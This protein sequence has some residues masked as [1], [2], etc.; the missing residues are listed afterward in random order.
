MR[1]MMTKKLKLDSCKASYVFCIFCCLF[2]HREKNEKDC[3]WS[4]CTLFWMKL[5]GFYK[6]E[7]I[8]KTKF[9]L[10]EA[11]LEP[12]Q[13]SN[14]EPFSISVNSF[15]VSTIFCKTLHLRSLIGIWIH[16][17]HCYVSYYCCNFQSKC[18]L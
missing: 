2:T 8:W 9:H 3:A 11:Y 12:C 6:I 13:T 10:L 17:W 7:D 16:L 5:H 14:M 1:E 15:W 18:Y 4:L